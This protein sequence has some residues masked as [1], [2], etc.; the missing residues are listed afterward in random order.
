MRN[1]IYFDSPEDL[2]SFSGG[3]V[4]GPR[5]N[6]AKIALLIPGPILGAYGAALNTLPLFTKEQQPWV[7][8]SLFV[9][10]IVG[11]AWLVGWQIETDT[12]KLRHEIVYAA[13]FVVWAYSLTGKTV[14]PW[15]YSPG[16]AALLPIIASV[17]F[18]QI[19][20]PKKERRRDR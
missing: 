9:L 18:T 10:G 7:G 4:V 20:L 11:T 5:E 13:A 16:M 3:R 8:L 19:P 1:W 14:L 17:I 2:M 6:I 15:I 12:K